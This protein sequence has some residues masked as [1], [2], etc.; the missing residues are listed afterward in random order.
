LNFARAC[1]PF[2]LDQKVDLW[3]SAKDT[4][5]AIYDARFRNIFEHE[6]KKNWK[7]KFEKEGIGRD[8]FASGGNSTGH[9]MS[10]NLRE[11]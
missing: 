2:A 5:S 8:V 3:F 7:A 4:I 11:N 9:Q 6:Y 10:L 1:F